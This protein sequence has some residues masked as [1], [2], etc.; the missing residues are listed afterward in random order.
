M[1][2]SPVALAEVRAHLNIDEADGHSDDEELWDKTLAATGLVERQVGVIR[3]REVTS[4]VR[5]D[6]RSLRLPSWPVVSVTSITDA[7]GTV[8]DATQWYAVRSDTI[9]PVFGCVPWSPFF[10]VVYTAGYDPIPDELLEA[11][12]LQT[13]L[14]WASQRGPES[15]ARFADGGSMGGDR[16]QLEKILDSF[17]PISAA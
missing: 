10:D 5:G 1:T 7:S 13:G 2:L 11:V 12:R 8:A 3:P 15:V 16:M 17:K 4:R 6:T 9:R 14:L